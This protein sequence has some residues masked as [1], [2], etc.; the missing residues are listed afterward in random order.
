MTHPAPLQGRVALVTGAA[1]GIG[2]A[3]AGELAARGATVVLNGRDET[4]LQ[5]RAAALSDEHGVPTSSF[6]A[7]ASDSQ[8]I[9]AGYRGVHK[10]HGRLDILVNN[11]GIMEDALL[12]MITDDLVDRTFDTNVRGAIAHLQAAAK[13]MRRGKSGSIINL[14]SIIGVRGNA[15]QSVY[16]ASKAALV[17]LTLSAAKELAPVGIR[18]NAIAPGHIETDL[19]AGLTPE[20]QPTVAMGRPG[21]PEDVARVVAFL[22]GDDSAYVTGQVLGVDGGMMI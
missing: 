14:T 9:S 11:A 21:T 19:T 10:E 6:V 22:A 15:G 4:V 12:G 7:D 5:E 18:V 3:T 16:A 13:L 2:W 20:Q 1:R 17:G 8:A